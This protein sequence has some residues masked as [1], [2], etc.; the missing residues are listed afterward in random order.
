MNSGQIVAENT[1]I[2]PCMNVYIS[3]S[4]LHNDNE[5]LKMSK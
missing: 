5:I 2:A 1:T 4:K 3:V